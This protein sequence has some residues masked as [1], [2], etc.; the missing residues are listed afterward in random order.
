MTPRCFFLWQCEKDFCRE[1]HPK[2]QATCCGMLGPTNGTRWR[3]CEGSPRHSWRCRAWWP[4]QPFLRRIFHFLDIA[5][6]RTGV[7]SPPSRPRSVDVFFYST[8]RVDHC[9]LTSVS[10]DLSFSGE[11]HQGS[12]GSTSAIILPHPFLPSTHFQSR[13]SPAPQAVGL[14]LLS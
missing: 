3:H 11:L 7:G 1:V 5:D 8:V 10:L 13:S 9:I 6:L 14:H 12:V 4:S 2:W